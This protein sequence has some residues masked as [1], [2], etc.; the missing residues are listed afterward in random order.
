MEMSALA[1]RFD[2]LAANLGGVFTQAFAVL[3]DEMVTE[4]KSQ[5]PLGK[6]RLRA[7]IAAQW[8][9]SK[10]TFRFFTKKA[11]Y[12]WA[13]ERGK[14]LTAQKGPY[15]VFDAGAGVRKIKSVKHPAHPFM[16]S[17]FNERFYP[18]GE[19]N[20]EQFVSILLQEAEHELS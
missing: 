3:G 18:G 8:T 5:A 11:P 7:S 16:L 17:V 2:A 6:G 14:D 20:L 15:L 10:N 1:G 19:K 12:A 13:V 9:E 4:A